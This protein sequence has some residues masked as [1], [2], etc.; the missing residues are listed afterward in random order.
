MVVST[1]VGTAMDIAVVARSLSSTRWL[2]AFSSCPALRPQV[3]GDLR[4]D[5]ILQAKGDAGAFK[6]ID[7][8]TYSAAA[9]GVEM[10]QLLCGSIEPAMDLQSH[11]SEIMRAY[12]DALHASGPE[13]CK[14][15][16]RTR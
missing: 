5:N 9:P 1:W 16:G 14:A 10:V 13:A 7:W 6:F 8:Q 12:L 15:C 2:K 3:H 11:V 4:C